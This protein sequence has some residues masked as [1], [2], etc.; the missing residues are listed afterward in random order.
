MS[1]PGRAPSRAALGRAR[2]GGRARL[3]APGLGHVVAGRAGTGERAER[4]ALV[5][6]GTGAV[7]AGE[8][9]HG[10]VEAG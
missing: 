3:G 6:A 10:H 9:R 2:R 4:A 1:A 7:R 8:P 5:R